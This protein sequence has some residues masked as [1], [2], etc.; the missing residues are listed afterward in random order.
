L[1]G[2]SKSLV[3]VAVVAVLGGA[4][5]FAS[6]NFIVS[7]G[8]FWV[9]TGSQQ[10]GH[11]WEPTSAVTG[12]T[13]AAGWEDWEAQLSYVAVYD[14]VN[15]C[16]WNAPI[17]LTPLGDTESYTDLNL[18]S[19]LYRDRFVYVGLGNNAI[20]DGGIGKQIYYGFS[21]DGTGS[22]WVDAAAIFKNS[23]AGCNS[24]EKV[25]WDYPSVAVDGGGHVIVG[26]VQMCGV[27]NRLNGYWIV[28]A[29]AFASGSAPN[30]S[31]PTFSTPV[32]LQTTPV[33]GMGVQEGTGAR[34]IATSNNVFEVFVPSMVQSVN[35][36]NNVARC[37]GILRS[38]GSVT[39]TWFRGV[40]EPWIG[41]T[42]FGEPLNNTYP[43][44]WEDKRFSTRPPN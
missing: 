23:A 30:F 15:C 17:L 9:S 25:A 35:L 37:E 39:W 27:N 32:Q 26:A 5:V 28:T 21:N 19:D 7:E 2:K 33:S 24:G 3:I 4:I 8:D 6:N 13:W 38:D 31:Q 12:V 29:F 36:P 11:Q 16:R 10:R 41:Q 22:S 20:P 44:L 14:N 34:V 1:S 40:L 42:P 18:A 43:T